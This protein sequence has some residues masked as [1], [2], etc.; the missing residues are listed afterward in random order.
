MRRISCFSAAAAALVLAGC[1]PPP[2]QADAATLTVKRLNLDN[3]ADGQ[4]DTDIHLVADGTTPA[5]D[6]LRVVAAGGVK[7]PTGALAVENGGLSV[8]NG[9]GAITW[10]Q[11]AETA[12]TITNTSAG[13]SASTAIVFKNALS[14]GETRALELRNAS[15]ASYPGDLLLNVPS[16]DQ[17]VFYSPGAAAA[18]AW[19]DET[20]GFIAPTVTAE[21][22]FIVEG[23]GST[24]APAIHFT[25]GTL[26][27]DVGIRIE[28]PNGNFVFRSNAVDGMTLNQGGEL[29]VAQR[30]LVLSGNSTFFEEN[31]IQADLSGYNTGFHFDAT[32]EQWEMDYAVNTTGVVLAGGSATLTAD[33]QTVDPST[34]GGRGRIQLDSDSTTAADRTF[35]IGPGAEAGQLLIIVFVG[36]SS[37]TCE[38][39]DDQ[40]ITGGN[41]RLTA[42]WTPSA[43]GTLTLLYDGADWIEIGRT[44]P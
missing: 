29:E 19:I 2:A 17:I 35:L 36:T 7:V 25:E 37:S 27:S 24:S 22:Q 14:S 44:A 8:E 39:R 40:A 1:A 33:D 21:D 34:L 38:L 3:D 13:S 32:D 6:A 42:D 15:H 20:D 18:M 10:G 16:G 28:G 30:V 4:V 43:D 41:I 11:N 12:L 23:L 9:N 5:S 26:P 31:G